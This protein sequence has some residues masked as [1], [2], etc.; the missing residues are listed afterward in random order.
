MGKNILYFDNDIEYSEIVKLLWNF[1]EDCD[2]K[3]IIDL[4]PLIFDNEHDFK[5]N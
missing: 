1:I 3:N 5:Y 2:E 4:G